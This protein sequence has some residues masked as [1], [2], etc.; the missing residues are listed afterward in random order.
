VAAVEYD[1]VVVGSGAGGATAAYVLVNLGLKVLLLE[2][3]RMLNPA[4]DFVTHDRPWDLKF[5]GD[6][7][8]GEYDGLW[9]INEY[10][11]HLYTNPRKEQ[12]D[13]MEQFHW[14]RLRAVGG[15]TN[16]W[17]RSC[18]RHGPMDFKT[19]STQG[20][21]E[22]WP[23]SYE[24]IAPYYDRVER[25][26]GISGA[27]DGYFN[28]PD[29]LYSGPPHP[30][31]CTEIDMRDKL[32]RIGVPVINGRTAVLSAP[33][34]G[35]P[36]CH[37]CGACGVGCDVRARFS[38]LDVI[39][40]KL[41]QKPNFTLRT[42]AVAYRVLV[43]A[44]G[45]ASGVSFID[46]NDRK[47]YEVRAKAVV[48]AASSAET[49]RIL[50]NSKSRFHPNGLANSSGL[51]GHYLMDTTK[52]GAMIGVVPSWRNR[53]RQNED[54]AGGAHVT[55]PRF[56]Y[57]RR[58]NFHGGYF[59]LFGTGFGRSINADVK[60]WGPALKEEIYSQYGSV[61]SLRGY[62]ECM[63]DHN[64]FFEID[65]ER[66]DQYGIPQLRFRCGHGENEIKMMS[67]IY[68]WMEQV[69][70]ALGAEILPYVQRLEP[71]GDATHECGT[72]RM[73][74]DPKTS[75]LNPF[76]QSHDVQ[77]LF[78]TDGS[79]FVSLP[80]THGITTWMM[81]LSWRASEYLA[82]GLKKGEIHA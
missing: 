72:A 53:K 52:S 47:D 54:G 9:K 81:S 79:G 15:R 78:V 22:D 66:K 26:V 77:N 20:F 73:G 1:V 59:L 71:L 16:T 21:G 48:L 69:M 36:A 39:I 42:H 23:I 10:T 30:W 27:K 24:D 63:P 80:A 17:G 25:L 41:R 49:G 45:R 29:G 70:K 44:E 12:Y 28:M 11:A 62:G 8:P 19:K 33:Y 7:K 32:A 75:V 18:Y 58:D 6:G 51:I 57:N 3:G 68:G 82:E 60:G 55:I 76:C 67:D 64:N 37:Y 5:R 61:L 65:P 2:A 31:R 34:D 43:N 46:S 14:T 38:T 50:L 4:K 35:R 13:S 74:T 56:N 40:P